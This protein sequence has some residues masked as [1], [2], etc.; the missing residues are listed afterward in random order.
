MGVARV[1]GWSLPCLLGCSST[2]KPSSTGPNDAGRPTT[3]AHATKDARDGSQTRADAKSSVDASDAQT[4]ALSVPTPPDWRLVVE[5]PLFKDGLGRTV[6]LRGVDAGGR[7]KFAPYVPFDYPSGGYAAAL[8][9]YMA[10]AESW[11]IDAMRVPFTW[12]ALEPTRTTPPTYDTAWLT[13]Y[14]AL[15]EAAWAHGIYTVVDFHQDVYSEVFCGDGFP[16][17]TLADSGIEAGAPAHD[18]PQWE[19]EYLSDTSV[20]AAFDDFWPATSQTMTGYFAAWDEMISQVSD[21]PGVIGFEPINEPAAGT[22]NLATFESTTLSSFY[23]AIAAKMNQQAPKA[24]VFFDASELDGVTVS[25][26]LQKPSGTNLVFAPHFYPLGVPSP[27]VVESNLATW[28]GYRQTWNLPVFV[29]EFGAS[30]T[31]STTEPYIQS[32][33]AALDTL[34]L[35]GTEWEYSVSADSWNSESDSVVGADGGEFPVA[36]ALIRPFARAVAGTDIVQSWDTTT[37]PTFTLQYTASGGVTEVR[38]PARAYPAPPK[39]TVTG[40]CVDATHP[41]EL[42][43]SAS[44]GAKVTLVVTP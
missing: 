30:N 40:G 1:L 2:S 32:V 41:G 17:W 10:R 22:A 16:A 23:S 15:L 29:G 39:V 11:G 24:L 7:S 42:L 18:C 21:T 35:S 36:A 3:D 14:V 8:D 38:L 13:Q 26:S 31:V 34:G 33:F 27:S 25:T 5:G 4:C 19:L 28:A 9:A 20:Q 44:S 37:A 6:F 12:A 43:V